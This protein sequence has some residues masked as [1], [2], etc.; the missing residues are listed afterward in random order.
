VDINNFI[1]VLNVRSATIRNFY[2]PVPI[3]IHSD[4]LLGSKQEKWLVGLSLGYT[5][6]A[7]FRNWNFQHLVSG[8]NLG[9][10]PGDISTYNPGGFVFRLRVGMS[11]TVKKKERQVE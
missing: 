8:T 4:F 10:S 6:A 5:F 2:I 1:D 9:S 11:S 7:T 3:S